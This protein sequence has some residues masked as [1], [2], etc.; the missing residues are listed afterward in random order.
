V[1]LLDADIYGPSVPLLVPIKDRTVHKS[2]SDPKAVEPLVGPHGLKVLSFG[3]VNPKAGEQ[4]RLRV[5]AF[6]EACIVS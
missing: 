3:Y 6:T 1:G 5:F 4:S 2:A